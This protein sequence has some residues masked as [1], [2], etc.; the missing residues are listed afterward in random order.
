MWSFHILSDHF[1]YGILHPSVYK[2]HPK[3]VEHLKII[4]IQSQIKDKTHKHR[5]N[6]KN[7]N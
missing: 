7:V 4:V 3:N 1:E 2:I 6:H 5:E